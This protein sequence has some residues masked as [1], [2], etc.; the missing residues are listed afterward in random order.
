MVDD[1]VDSNCGLASLTIADDQLALTTTD[2]H[3]RVDRFK[4]CLQWLFNGLSINYTWCDAFYRTVVLSNN[5]TSIIDWIAEHIDYATDK[6]IADGHLHNAT[7]AFHQIAFANC[8]KLTEQ[9]RTDFIL[10]EIERQTSHVVRKLEQFT[11]HHL[12]QTVK[13]GNA[14]ADFNHGAHFTDR[15]SGFEVLDLFADDLVNFTRFYWFH[16][17]L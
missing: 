15:D 12:F 4:T 5:W 14:V 17:F 3:H 13:L 10:F 8:L 1:R 6:R 16:I 2:R 11:G 9:H 7:G